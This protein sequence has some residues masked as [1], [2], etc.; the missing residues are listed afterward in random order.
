MSEEEVTSV[1]MSVMPPRAE[2]NKVN[3]SDHSGVSFL[4]RKHP[5]F[6]ILPAPKVDG[7]NLCY[8]K[9]WKVLRVL[10]RSVWQEPCGWVHRLR[11]R[12]ITKLAVHEKSL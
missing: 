10:P 2:R 3:S 7:G 8:S 12:F 4:L 5:I 9:T 6:N 1:G 11:G